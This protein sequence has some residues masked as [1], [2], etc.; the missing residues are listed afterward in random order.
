[1]RA[2]RAIVLSTLAALS[3]LVGTTSA[4]SA[5][6]AAIGKYVALGDSY[7]VGVGTYGYDDPNDPCRRGPFAYP[8]LWA[9]AHP[10]TAFVE[11]SCSGAET[12]DVLT[13]QLPLVTPDTS[14]VTIQVGGNDAGFVDVLVGCTFGSDADCVARTQA[15]SQVV[16]TTVA[17]ALQKTYA[18]VRANAP[19]ARVVVIGYPRI[20]KPGGTCFGQLSA[21]KQAAINASADVL[22][23]VTAAQAS[24]A[25]FT[26]LDARATFSGHEI[27][28]SDW[29]L[30]ALEI[31]KLNESFHPNKK[32]HQ[33]GYFAP[34]NAITG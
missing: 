13:S 10:S 14:L 26:F 19:S 16:R 22:A 17:P 21:P 27:C 1:M 29:Y 2:F 32:G 6:P 31:F 24:A 9:A 5:A 33:L 28:T 18:A 15:A 8:R 3:L 30:T 4:A 12:A 20:Y 11:A 34:L 7:A 25:G 23:S